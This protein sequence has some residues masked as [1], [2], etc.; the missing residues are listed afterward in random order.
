MNRPGKAR[1][2][3]RAVGDRGEVEVP[4]ER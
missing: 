4:G 3:V 1:C 2:A